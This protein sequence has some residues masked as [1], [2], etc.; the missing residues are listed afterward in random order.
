MKR[1]EEKEREGK[2]MEKQRARFM[3]AAGV[4]Y[5]ES[6]SWRQGHAGAS[7]DEIIEQVT[8]QRRGLMGKL[9]AELALALGDGSEAL[10]QPCPKCSEEVQHKGQNVRGVLHV[11]GESAI[12]R[13]HS[14]C[15]SCASG[16]FPP[17]RKIAL[18]GS[19]LDAGHDRA[20]AAGGDRDR[21]V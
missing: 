21:L 16:F 3:E 15:P 12:K 14:Y 17:G 4:M 20:G 7:L 19:E 9:V 10:G 11:E 2:K 18:G 1:G 8:P 13:T 6:F 5:D